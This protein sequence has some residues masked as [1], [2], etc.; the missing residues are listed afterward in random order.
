MSVLQNRGNARLWSQ[1]F[2]RLDATIR[3]ARLE[4]NALRKHLREKEL[5]AIE[6]K[7]VQSDGARGLECEYT[8]L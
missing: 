2:S 6:Q 7:Q 4:G 8:E 1:I 5:C 3:S